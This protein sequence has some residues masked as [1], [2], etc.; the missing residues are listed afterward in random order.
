MNAY[1]SVRG[2]SHYLVAEKQIFYDATENMRFIMVDS[3]PVFRSLGSWM[4][5]KDDRGL[6]AR[7]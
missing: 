1:P 2:Y 7:H 4:I 6:S 3:A 5:Q